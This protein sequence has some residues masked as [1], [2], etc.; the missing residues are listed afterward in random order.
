MARAEFAFEDSAEFP[1]LDPGLEARRIQLLGGRGEED[2]DAGFFGEGGVALLFARICSEIFARPELG[3]VDEQA[4]DDDLVFLAGGAEEREMALV[5]GAHRR[6]ETERRSAR[7]EVKL[8][9]RP[10]DPHGRVASARRSYSGSRS[11]RV[12]R[13]AS[14]CASTVS[15]SPRS[16]G[17]VSSKPFSIVRCISGTSASGGAPAAWMRSEATLCSVTR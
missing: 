2:I 6:H 12:E 13:I 15:Q 16:I 10:D 7:R 8:P 1:D 14:R 9:D 3:R 4:G 17:P 5:K 11:G